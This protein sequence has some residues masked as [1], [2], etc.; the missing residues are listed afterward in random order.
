[1]CVIL[2]W[3]S[4]IKSSFILMQNVFNVC[5]LRTNWL[6][7]LILEDLGWIQVFLKNFS[8]HTHA[9]FIKQCALRSFCIK[10]LCFSKIWFFQT[11]DQSKLRLKFLIWVYLTRLMFDRFSIDR[12]WKF[13][14]FYV[15]DQI[16]FSM[17]HLCLGFTCIAL[18]FVSILQ[19]LESYLYLFSH[20]PCIYFVKLGTQLDLK[21][22]W[23][24]FE[25]FVYFSICYFLCVNCRKFFLKRYEG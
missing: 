16:F 19:V 13:F 6:K 1:M 18:F 24:I 9:F 25:S 8:S 7:I 4:K 23:L 21:I 5:A 14:S 22:D 2:L 20:I 10:M 12:N 17:H 3:P 15:F 11:F